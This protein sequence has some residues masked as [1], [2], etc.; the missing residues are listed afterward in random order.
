MV[1]ILIGFLAP[2]A[3]R[4]HPWVG[5]CFFAS[6]RQCRIGN[7][8]AI[9]QLSARRPF[10]YCRADL[11]NEVPVIDSTATLARV[12]LAELVGA[13]IFDCVSVPPCLRVSL[14]VSFIDRLRLW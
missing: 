1:I 3:I 4:F 13:F 5:L 14:C 8:P 9:H 2:I 12:S 10:G 6:D 7:G 11:E